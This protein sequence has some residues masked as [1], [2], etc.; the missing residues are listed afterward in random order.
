MSELERKVILA[1]DDTRSIR[2]FLRILLQ[3]HGASFHE[4]ATATEGVRMC[5]MVRPDVVVLDL[6]LPDKDGL[7]ILS[8]IKK[9]VSASGEAPKVVILSVRKEQGVR[10]R[11]FRNGADAYVTKPFMMEELMEALSRTPRGQVEACNRGDIR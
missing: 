10:E 1:I 7:D 3:G 6:G 8:D 2:I 4:A 5:E 11:A 9:T